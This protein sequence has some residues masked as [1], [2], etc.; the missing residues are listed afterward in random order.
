VIQLRHADAM[1]IPA[2]SSASAF[3]LHTSKFTLEVKQF[4]QQKILTKSRI[5]QQCG[6]KNKYKHGK[7]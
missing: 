4:T 3:Y 6:A 7:C 2:T 1:V 5:L